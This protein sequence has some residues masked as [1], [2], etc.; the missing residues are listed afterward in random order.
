MKRDRDSAEKSEI[1][2][3]VSSWCKGKLRNWVRPN[4]QIFYRLYK[5][6]KFF[7][8]NMWNF[9]LAPIEE[10]LVVDSSSAGPASFYVNKATLKS[11]CLNRSP[12][13]SQGVILPSIFSHYLRVYVFLR[14]SLES[15][16]FP[17]DHEKCNHSNP[18][19]QIKPQ[20]QWQISH[21]CSLGASKA[22]TLVYF[23][24]F[25]RHSSLILINRCF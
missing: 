22:K 11:S 12:T 2:M 25:H 1:L 6:G 23:L 10:R 13:Y 3:K 16:F 8:F 5:I 4:F 19:W 9:L 15:I 18:L 21:T 7:Y 20:E 24:L 14:F 17:K